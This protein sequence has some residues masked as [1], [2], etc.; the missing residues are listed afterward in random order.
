MRLYYFPASLNARR[1]VMTAI[2]LGVDVD[3]VVVDLA[4]GEQRRADF[5][6]K[7]P[8]GKVPVLED[9]GFV[10]SESHAIMQYL[11]DRTPDQSLYPG[12][13][14]A[15][16]DVNRWLF[17]SAHHFTPAV[18]ILNWENC[19]RRILGL[20]EPDPVAVKRGEAL[21]TEGA[22]VLDAHLAGKPW[23]AQDRL[24]LADLAIAAPLM[25]I[26]QAKL[27]VNDFANLM[28]WLRRVQSLDAWKKTDPSDNRFPLARQMS[29]CATP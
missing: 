8:N 15:R 18:S 6:E 14:R 19:V 25:V 1:A 20:G 21:V 3:L 26:R 4:K 2:H 9:D 5:L 12:E 28:V 13:L 11:A 27:P 17:W 10:L 16:A 24:T 23:I 7:N 22:R 29:D